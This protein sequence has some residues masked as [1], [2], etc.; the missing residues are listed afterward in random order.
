MKPDWL[1]IKNEY[2]NSEIS[3]RELAKAEGLSYAAVRN[4]AE[5]EDW[6]TQRA[7]QQRKINAKTAQKAVERISDRQASRAVDVIEL[8][9]LA[10]IRAK[11]FLKNPDLKPGEL[12][13]VTGALKDLSDIQRNSIA[14]P[15]VPATRES[16]KEL[17][18]EELRA[19]ANE[20]IKQ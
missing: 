13:S 2:I 8:N 14:V 16:A 5:R 18:T 17:T 15:A 12:K 11:G 3:Q 6:V 20:I 7:T 10:S 4:R 1:K 19:L 9:D